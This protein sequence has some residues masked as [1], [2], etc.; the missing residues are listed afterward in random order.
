[1]GVGITIW[2]PGDS[3]YVS[4]A[5]API[6]QWSHVPIRRRVWSIYVE[7][8]KEGGIF[9]SFISI[10]FPAHCQVG[11]ICIF[12]HMCPSLW[13]Q[14]WCHL[15][16]NID[17]VSGYLHGDPLLGIMWHLWW[18]IY[19]LDLFHTDLMIL[20]VHCDQNSM[21][22][23]GSPSGQGSCGICCNG[24]SLVPPSWIWVHV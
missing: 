18:N 1:M 20:L 3:K 24:L 5:C 10:L 8:G 14:W 23:L 17:D 11:G 13:Y 19:F 21:W 16:V 15:G 7:K 2:S 4:G 12:W 9:S 6:S 22:K